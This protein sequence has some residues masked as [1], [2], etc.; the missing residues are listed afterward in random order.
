MA[1]TAVAL[2]RYPVKSMLGEE[3]PSVEVAATG[4]AGDRGWALLDAETG[5]V[6]SAKSPGSGA[7]C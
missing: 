7:T 6:A 3:L 5:R 1:G 4:L 2:R